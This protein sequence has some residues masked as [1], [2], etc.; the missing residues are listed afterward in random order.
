VS[1]EFKP[2]WTIAPGAML[3][4]WLEENNLSPEV[5]AVT[6]GGRAYK[7][8]ALA[9]ITEVL[10]RKP[11]RELNALCLERGTGISAQFWLNFEHNYRAGLAAGLVDASDDSP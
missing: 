3:R 10:D 4:F 7:A 1:Y 8:T 11:L 5:L 9:L 2:D 6:C